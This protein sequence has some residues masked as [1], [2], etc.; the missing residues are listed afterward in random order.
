[1]RMGV[2]VPLLDGLRGAGGPASARVRALTGSDEALL[3]ALADTPPAVRSTELIAVTTLS[4]GDAAPVTPDMARQLTAGD[5]E[6][7]LLACASAT[8]GEEVDAVVECP[9]C[10]E[11][12]ELPIPL[13]RMLAPPAPGVRG[14]HHELAVQT[15]DGTRL[16]RFRLPTG[17]DLEAA[18]HVAL[19]QPEQGA[20]AVLDRCVIQVTTEAGEPAPGPLASDVAAAVDE[21]I[22]RLD[23]AAESVGEAD[24]PA[25]G[26]PVRALLDA[27]CLLSSGLARGERL[28]TEVA[29]LARAYHWSEAEILALPLARRRRYLELAR[30]GADS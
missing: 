26:T 16:V 17:A 3:D 2:T 24:C 7:L 10:G 4:V 21:A 9:H 12:V 6:R 13:G 23:P 25:C 19:A 20:A 11:L 30:A 27:F 22:A 5:R 28:L 15:P 18:A 1:M 29:S 14:V 8:L